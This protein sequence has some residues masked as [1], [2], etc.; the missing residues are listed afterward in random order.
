M[1]KSIL[2]TV[3]L[4]ALALRA[5]AGEPPPRPFLPEAAA[6]SHVLLVNVGGAMPEA[7]FAKAAER[8]CSTVYVNFWTNSIPKSVFRELIEDPSLLKAKFGK[9]V[10]VAV[11]IE[12]N[13]KGPSFLQSPGAW[14]MVNLRGLDRDKPD[15][16]KYETRCAKMVLKGI[17]YACGGGNTLERVCDMYCGSFTLAGMDAA[18]LTISPM[19]YFPMLE[20]LKALGG[21]EV[22]IPENDVGLDLEAE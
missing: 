11:F 4:L 16:A 7:L 17:A 6:R 9:K 19:A 12:R 22:L 21:P 5:G 2:A 8:A 1:D 18:N 10:C 15:A 13:E 20:I 3:S 14:S